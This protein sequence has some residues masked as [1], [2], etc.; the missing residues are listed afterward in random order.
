MIDLANTLLPNLPEKLTWV[1]G[2]LY[3]FMSLIF[4]I[5]IVLPFITIFKILTHR[6]RRY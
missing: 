6:K 2:V 4:L 1:Y 3:L 5:L